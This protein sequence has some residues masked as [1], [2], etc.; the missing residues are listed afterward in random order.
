M[1]S[2]NAIFTNC[3]KTDDGDVWWEG[4]TGEPP[5][6]AI[7]WHG[8]D[9]TPEA[10]DAAAHPNARFTV[11]VPRSARRSRPNGRIPRGC[12]SR[13]SCSA[14][15][16]STTVPLVLEARDWEHGVF[17]GSIMSSEM[18]AAAVG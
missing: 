9:W 7:D 3:A 11:A 2:R 5:A 18:T 14:A 16:G 10:D 4:L 8:N 6:H 13:R 1:I 17:L 12:R 15:G